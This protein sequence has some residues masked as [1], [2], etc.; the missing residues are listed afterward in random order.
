MAD[1]LKV[2]VQMDPLEGINISG[3]STFALMLEAQ[4]RGHMLWHYEVRHLS[5]REGRGAERVTALARPVRVQR[6]EGAHF[7]AGAPQT[8][9]LATMDVVLMRQ[10][11]PFDMAYISATHILEHVHPR[12][13]VVNDP[14]SVRN[15]PEKLLV[16]HFPE[17]MPPTLVTWD[18]AAIRAFRSEFKDIISVNQRLEVCN[19]KLMSL[20][21]DKI[22]KDP[23]QKIE[24]ENLNYDALYSRNFQNNLTNI[25]NYFVVNKILKNWENTTKVNG[26]ANTTLNHNTSNISNNQHYRNSRASVRENFVSKSSFLATNN[27]A[28]LNVTTPQEV[29]Y[30][31]FK[32]TENNDKEDKSK[33]I[34]KI[35]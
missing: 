35:N 16:T 30:S 11:P 5:L 34:H 14:A 18:A 7:T 27:N 21:R 32:P 8:L 24:V 31:N 12:T 26:N 22:L 28:Y 3:D 13:L 6:A 1:G 29:K 17:L 10:D 33:K 23:Y 19:L 9:N 2:A 15:A 25:K 4:A 20:K